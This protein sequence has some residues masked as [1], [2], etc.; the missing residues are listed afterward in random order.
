MT[1]EA[2]RIS[3][4][5]IIFVSGIILGTK[6]LKLNGFFSLLFAAVVYGLITGMR[7]F[8]IL[9]AKQAG[10][11]TLLSAENAFKSFTLLTILHG[12]T[13]LLTTILFSLVL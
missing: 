7:F 4:G 5:L 2:W 12:V 9:S 3:I 10:F 13:V 6:Y 8:E 11:G 1:A